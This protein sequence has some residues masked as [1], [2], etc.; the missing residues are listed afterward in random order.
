MNQLVNKATQGDY[1]SIRR[2][3]SYCSWLHSELTE[4]SRQLGGLSFEEGE[5]I[6]RA[7]LGIRDEA[8]SVA[9][10][11]PSSAEHAPIAVT[12]EVQPQEEEKR[13]RPSEVG[14]GRPPVQSR[15][16]KGRS[17]NPAG[18][19]PAVKTFARLIRRLLLEKIRITE[20]G[21]PRMVVRLQVVFD[22]IV[23]RAALGNSRFLKLL[24]EYIPS[25]DAVLGRKRKLRKN[26]VQI[27]RK[28]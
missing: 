10:E 27:L 28:G 26:L 5:A 17:G 22:Q 25:V 18:R 24:L 7:L 21:Y 16:R 12:P 9:K 14:F 3:V 4:P 6:R 11:N 2:L 23:N 19:P 8:G 20:N 15:F 1:Q 13:I